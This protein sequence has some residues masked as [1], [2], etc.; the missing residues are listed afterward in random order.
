MPSVAAVGHHSVASLR[1][2]LVA[3][4]PKK[5]ADISISILAFISL[6]SISSSESVVSGISTSV[7][8]DLSE[9]LPFAFGFLSKISVMC[10]S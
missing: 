6:S 7:L 10:Y 3:R 1:I 2:S 4:L 9:A 8:L 5:G